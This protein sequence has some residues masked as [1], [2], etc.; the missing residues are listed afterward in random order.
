[1]TL[2]LDEFN[3]SEGFL[4]AGNIDFVGESGKISG[5]KGFVDSSAAFGGLFPGF[6]AIA[7]FPTWAEGVVFQA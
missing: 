4:G 1:V 7:L 5:F 3:I 6:F 2:P